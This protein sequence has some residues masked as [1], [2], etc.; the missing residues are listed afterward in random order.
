MVKKIL[1]NSPAAAKKMIGKGP[2]RK[3]GKKSPV[4][5][6]PRL[7]PREEVRGQ[8]VVLIP[9]PGSVFLKE[10]VLP[11][12]KVKIYEAVRVSGGDTVEM[13]AKWW[14]RQSFFSK[15]DAIWKG[16]MKEIHMSPIEFFKAYCHKPQRFFINSLVNMCWLQDRKLNA[17]QKELL[18]RYVSLLG[19]NTL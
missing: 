9:Q 6:Q 4:V 14:Y 3:P 10:S 7:Q 17:I 11:E 19:K 13:H 12:T 15:F 5:L 8:D 1:N 16:Y 2:G 18:K